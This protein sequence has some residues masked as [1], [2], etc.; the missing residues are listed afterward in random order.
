MQTHSK[1]GIIKWKVLLAD[2]QD[3]CTIDLSLV[4]R[5]SYKSALKA[6]VRF[7][8]M[9]KQ[10]T[11][12]HAQGNWSLVPLPSTKNL[13]ACKSIFKLKKHFDGSITRHKA[14]SVAKGFHQEPSLDYGETFSPMVKPTTVRLVL[15][16]AAYFNWPFRQLDVKNAL[17]HVILQEEAYMFQP[18]GFEDPHHSHLV[19]KLHKSFYG[20]KQAP[21]AWK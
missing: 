11:A 13:V 18:P 20:F 7:T 12:L 4:E 15:A 17:L 10:L 3:S 9:K 1:S 2:I 5:A 19:C 21:K 14:Q 16:L 6:L 8:A